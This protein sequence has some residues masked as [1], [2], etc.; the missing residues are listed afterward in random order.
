MDKESEKFRKI[1]M[2]VL[3]MQLNSTSMMDIIAYG[4]ATVGMISALVLFSKGEISLTGVLMIL[5][6]AAECLPRRLRYFGWCCLGFGS[7]AAAAAAGER[8]RARR[9]FL[10]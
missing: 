9:S 8:Y 5:F 1:T 6:L 7:A 4:G 2:K 10:G 3:M